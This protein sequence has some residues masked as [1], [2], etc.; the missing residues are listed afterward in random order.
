M[1]K[2]LGLNFIIVGTPLYMAP[3]VLLNKNYSSKCDIWYIFF[4]FIKYFLI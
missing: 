2:S 3:E 1:D 4:K